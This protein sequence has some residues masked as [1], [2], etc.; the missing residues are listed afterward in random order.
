MNKF[1]VGDVVCHRA[2]F[3]RSIGWYTDVPMNGEV[4]EVGP[5][6]LKVV[7]NDQPDAD[8]QRILPANVIHYDRRH[9]EA[10]S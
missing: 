7:W 8:P 2:A 5:R 3:L 6:F 9:L 1:S 4:R 10:P